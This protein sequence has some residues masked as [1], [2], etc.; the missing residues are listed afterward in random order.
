MR[1]EVFAGLMALGLFVSGHALADTA[2]ITITPEQRTHITEF[3]TKQ[4]MQPVT[5]DTN[6]AV[7]ATLPETVVLQPVPEDWG[8]TFTTYQYVYTS[9]GVVLVDPNT[10]QVVEIIAP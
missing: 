9:N 2:K 6:I 1:R 4:N 10:R 3:V 5:V 7:G 8:P